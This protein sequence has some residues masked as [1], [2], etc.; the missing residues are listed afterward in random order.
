[1]GHHLES[2]REQAHRQSHEEALEK[3]KHKKDHNKPHRIEHHHK[4]SSEPVVQE[5]VFEEDDDDDH[6]H[7]EESEEG[8]QLPDPENLKIKMQKAI[9][10]L[11]EYFKSIRGAEPTPELFD[12]IT[13]NAYGENV[14]LA[15]VAQVVIVSPTLAHVTCFDPSLSS[16]VRDAIRDALELNPQLEEDGLVKC[17]LPRVSLETRQTTVKQLSKQAESARTK[18]RN[19]RRKAMEVI[20]LGKDGKLAG[21]GKEEAFRAGKEIE[22]ATE[23]MTKQVDAV[24]HEKEKSVMAV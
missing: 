1:M 2:L 24:L 8:P 23:E 3:R 6:H 17:P 11:S 4:E 22:A 16:D 13:V 9:D 18:I 5:L 7:D 15:A 12:T 21:I 19:I 14:P 10:R 20:K